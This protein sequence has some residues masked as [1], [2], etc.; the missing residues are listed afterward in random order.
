MLGLGRASPSTDPAVTDETVTDEGVESAIKATLTL[1]LGSSDEDEESVVGV[2]DLARVLRHLEQVAL[3]A[4]MGHTPE[5]Y[6]QETLDPP[7]VDHPGLRDHLC[8]RFPGFGLY[9]LSDTEDGSVE[10]AIDDLMDITR[11]LSEVFLASKDPAK[12][13]RE[14]VRSYE[15]HWGQHLRNLRRMLTGETEPL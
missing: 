2:D 7:Q 10:D 4:S 12:R 14:F 13:R 6:G 9:Q 11:D 1:L 3:A 8:S 15:T 5:S